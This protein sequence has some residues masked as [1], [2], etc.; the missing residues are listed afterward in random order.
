MPEAVHA[1]PATALERARLCARTAAENR[2]RDVVVLDLR[3]VTPIV[4]F[5]VLIS[6]TSRRQNHTLAEEIDRSME[7]AGD[8]RL[9]QEGYEASRWILLDYG[10]VVVHIFDVSVTRLARPPTAFDIVECWFCRA[11]LVFL[12]RPRPTGS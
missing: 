12:C 7:Q 3:N 9:G 1:R 5:F 11:S 6:G 8:H 10:D 2:G 4:D